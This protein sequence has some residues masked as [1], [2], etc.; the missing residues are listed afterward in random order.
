MAPTVTLLAGVGLGVLG[1]SHAVRTYLEYTDGQQQALTTDGGEPGG[2]TAS[3]APV[4]AEVLGQERVRAY[5]EVMA[6]IIELNRRAV[7][8]DAADLHEEADLLVHGGDSA[9][10]EPHANVTGTYQSYFHIISPAVREAVSTYADYLV[11]FHDDGAQAGEL[12]SRSGAVAEAMRSDLRLEPLF[13]RSRDGDVAPSADNS[14]TD[15]GA[16][17]S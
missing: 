11:T 5:R 7:E 3:A 4:S 2:A 15:T 10:D 14:D 17:D 9:L 8:M 16:D 1:V 13:D 12:L 6:A